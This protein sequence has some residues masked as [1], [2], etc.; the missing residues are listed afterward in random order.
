MLEALAAGAGHR[1][2]MRGGGERLAYSLRSQ[3]Q[4]I[5]DEQELG[6]DAITLPCTRQA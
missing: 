4:V 3:G 2:G 5:V 6:H 1:D